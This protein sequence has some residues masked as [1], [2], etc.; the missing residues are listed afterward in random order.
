MTSGKN[1]KKKPVSLRNIERLN[2][3]IPELGSYADIIKIVNNLMIDKEIDYELTKPVIS[4]ALKGESH[5]LTVAF[6]IL[7]LDRDDDE[8]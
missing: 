2:A 6:L 1:L 8:N 5:P 7:A 4:R 3:L